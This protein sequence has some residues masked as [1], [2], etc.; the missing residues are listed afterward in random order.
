[1]TTGTVEV[2]ITVIWKSFDQRSPIEKS[3]IKLSHLDP[4]VYNIDLIEIEIQLQ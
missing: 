3:C 2:W 1:M 4:N